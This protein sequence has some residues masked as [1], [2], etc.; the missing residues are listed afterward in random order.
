MKLTYLG[1]LVI[2]LFSGCTV[3]RTAKAELG[4]RTNA[5]ISEMRT[6]N[7]CPSESALLERKCQPNKETWHWAAGGTNERSLKDD[8]WRPIL[9]EWS[10]LNKT[11]NL[12]LDN[13]ELREKAYTSY[14]ASLYL[15]Y[16]V[17][18]PWYSW[19]VRGRPEMMTV[20][21][22][23]LRELSTDEDG[24]GEPTKAGTNLSELMEAV[25][26]GGT[27]DYV[28]IDVF[29]KIQIINKIVSEIMSSIDEGQLAG[30]V[31]LENL[32]VSLKANLDDELNAS[33]F[34]TL[35]IEYVRIATKG[36]SEYSIK[37]SWAACRL[38]SSYLEGAPYIKSVNGWFVQGSSS[39]DSETSKQEIEAAIGSA[40]E[41]SIKELELGPEVGNALKGLKGQFD[42]K[43][44]R[45]TVKDVVG[46]AYTTQNPVFIPLHIEI[47][48]FNE[49]LL[50]VIKERCNPT[51]GT[52]EK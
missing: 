1:I 27:P 50:G 9:T 23:L 26:L 28:E 10:K 43:Y 22:A 31:T 30:G 46:S 29:V 3:F 18:Y 24:P 52:P 11:E 2:L 5:P 41:A 35:Q 36:N 7:V 20:S 15:Y 6:L 16:P 48:D 51:S 12:G 33:S 42:I 44:V 39:I 40:I 34:G 8:K 47:V 25:D 21:P 37:E 49:K 14:I 17:N 19:V 13:N 38:Y 45:K 4:S 32:E